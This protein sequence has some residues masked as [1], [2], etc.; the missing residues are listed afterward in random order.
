MTVQFPE[1]VRLKVLSP[2]GKL[3][4]SSTEK[5]KKTLVEFEAI[6]GQRYMIHILKD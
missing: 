6:N 4:K 2:E 1:N 5:E 3:M